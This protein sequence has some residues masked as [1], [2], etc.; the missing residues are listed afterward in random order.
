M[1]MTPRRH[2]LRRLAGLALAPLATGAAARALAQVPERFPQRP[3]T[4]WVPWPAG[5]ATDLTMRLLAD[6]ASRQLG[7]KVIVENRSG[8]GGTLVMPILQQ[9]QADGYTIAQ[10]PQPVFRAPH[11]QKLLWDPIRDTTPLI[12]ISGVTFGMVVPAGSPWRSLDEV[13]SWARANPGQ[14]TV[15]TNGVGTTPHVVLDE[16]FAR[17]GIG[18]V[19]VPYKGTAEQMIAVSS[20]QVM[21]GVNSNGFAPFVDS[22]KLRLLVTF[23]EHRTRRWPQVPTLKELGHG[24]VAQS[25]YGLAGPRGLPP[26]VVRTLHDAFKVAMHEPAH[27]AELE[28][29]DQD[30]AYLGP[31]DY[32]R[33]MRETF[34]AERRTV[35]RLGLARGTP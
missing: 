27:L 16:L 5:G 31:D 24:I 35:E 4:L 9:A 1:E 14:L 11:V 32:G 6:G 23:G 17:R 28:R 26:E 22:G 19:H 2:A 29:Y 7:Q 34:A 3:V 25:P 18:W 13:F 30:L 20:G 33:A 21:V 10:M 8:A 12:Q 15:A